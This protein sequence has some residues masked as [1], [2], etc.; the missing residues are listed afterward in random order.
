MN[1]RRMA[2]AITR[3]KNRLLAMSEEELQQALLERRGSAFSTALLSSGAFECRESE[4]Q[5]LE[6][7]FVTIMGSINH[8]VRSKSSAIG[9]VTVESK[10]SRWSLLSEAVDLRVFASSGVNKL[11]PW[12]A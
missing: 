12:A 2:E 7:T 11:V 6:S 9:Q 5:S 10:G 4:L 8:P 1:S 3:A